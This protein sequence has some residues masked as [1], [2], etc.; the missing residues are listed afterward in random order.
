LSFYAGF[1]EHPAE[2]DCRQRWIKKPFAVQIVTTTRFKVRWFFYFV[3]TF[4]HRM[5]R[6]DETRVLMLLKNLRRIASVIHEDR[7]LHSHFKQAGERL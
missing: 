5:L 1:K 3:M 2:I 6:F 4:T 7:D